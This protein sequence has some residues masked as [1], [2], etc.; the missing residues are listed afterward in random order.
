MAIHIYCT[1]CYTSN[2][3]KAK[4]CSN[5]GAIFGRDKKYR[6]CVSVKGERRTRVE[7]NLTLAKQKEATL[8]ADLEGRYGD[9]KE[10]KEGPYPQ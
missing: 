6:V 1:R 7:N 2:G 9:E 3:L 10:E 8:Q 5:C 4:S